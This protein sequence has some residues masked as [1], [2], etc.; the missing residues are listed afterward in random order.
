MD[1]KDLK[2]GKTYHYT[3]GAEYV[4]VQYVERRIN[5]YLFT[6]GKVKNE[7]TSDCVKHHLEEL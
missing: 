3:A 5:R 7:L 4:K 1:T 6:D 2:K